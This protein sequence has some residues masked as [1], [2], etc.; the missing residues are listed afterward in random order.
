[1]R[2]SRA[3][4]SIVAA[5]A[6]LLL[7]AVALSSPASGQAGS[8]EVSG[9][10][11]L[12]PEAKGSG[13]V[14]AADEW[15]TVGGNFARTADDSVD[16]VLHPLTHLWTSSELI[17]QIYG[18]PLIYNGMI[19]VATERDVAYGLSASTGKVVWTTT[20]G[21][22]APWN[23]F[24]GGDISPT[25]GVTS[26]MVLDPATGQ[27]FASGAVYTKSGV[28]DDLFALDAATG[29]LE[30]T[31]DI[32]PTNH[33]WYPRA[34]L[35][36]MGLALADGYVVMGFGS[37]SCDCGSYQGAIVA[38]AENDKGPILDWF[39]PA[40]RGGGIW[41]PSGA[42]VDSSGDIFVSTGNTFTT[43]TNDG[44][45]DSTL[46]L[47]LVPHPPAPALPHT[48]LVQYFT[49]KNWHYFNTHDEDLASS[50]PILLG[51]DRAVVI[52][53]QRVMYLLDT[54]HLGGV[55][56]QLTSDTVCFARGGNAWAPPNLYVG[57]LL[58]GVT[59][60]HVGPGNSLTVGWTAPVT[61]GGPPTVAGGL[62]WTINYRTGTLYGLNPNNGVVVVT[63]QDNVPVNHFPG[64]S[65]GEGLLVVPA[66]RYVVAYT[67]PQGIRL[68]AKARR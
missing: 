8:G 28:R 5:L 68:P 1:V 64:V 24:K 3:H 65:A 7:V 23:N 62:V 59:Q 21:T 26:A 19:Y 16:P 42:T 54:S 32:D 41:A 56:G 4:L 12:A 46:E 6:S 38:A 61:T 52:G 67:G 37:H 17:G 47:Q 25:V 22:P 18:E 31:R 63:E 49:P 40:P 57:C 10:R 66:G 43:P 34:V 36:R 58:K 2:L 11:Q 14:P 13:A 53:K 55:D 45:G 27:L 51:G 30:W 39:V 9:Y 15:T 33:P 44:Y 29:A 50:S 60:V 20:L 48:A 35:Q